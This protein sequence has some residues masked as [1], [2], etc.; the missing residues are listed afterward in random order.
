MTDHNLHSNRDLDILISVT[1]I[2]R[3]ITQKKLPHILCKMYITRNLQCLFILLLN[4]YVMFSSFF[5]LLKCF[6][7]AVESNCWVQMHLKVS[8]I[9]KVA[10]TAATLPFLIRGCVWKAITQV[11]FS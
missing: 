11:K 1:F 6:N 7:I 10:Q 8:F 3:I 2:A 5:V 4:L 9:C